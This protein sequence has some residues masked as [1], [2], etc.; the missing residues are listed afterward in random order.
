MH[1]SIRQ[2]L[3]TPGVYAVGPPGAPIFSV[4]Q[5]MPDGRVFQLK[6]PKFTRDGELSADGWNPHAV[7]LRKLE[8]KV[9]YGAAKGVH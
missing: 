7:V 8:V 9:Q 3:G 4:V 5:V 1:D 2:M 6:P